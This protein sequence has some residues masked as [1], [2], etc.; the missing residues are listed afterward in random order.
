MTANPVLWTLDERGVAT[1]TLNRPEVNNA[2][3]GALIAGVLAAIDDLGKRP[4]LRVVVLRGNGKHFQAGADLKWIN[5]VR[6]QSAEAN[7]A[8]SRATFEAVQRLNTLPIPTVAL[9]Q[10]GCFGGGTGVIAACD[11]VIAADNALF[12]ITEVRWG[13]T[14]AIIIPQ[15]CDA[16]GVR[17]VR[18]YALTGERFGAEDARRIGLVHEVVPLAELEAAGAKVVEQLLANGPE[19]M[20]ETKRLALESSFGGM[21][22]DDAAYTR[23]V[24]LHSVKRQSSEAAEGLASFAETRAGNWGGGKG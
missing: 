18:R 24:H 14:A 4:N 16:I 9:V 6:P 19:A 20:A 2:Y 3:D 22:V 8:A 17:Q 1:V 11:V 21:A 7:E 12:S 10:G 15:L 23:L 5:G 13:L